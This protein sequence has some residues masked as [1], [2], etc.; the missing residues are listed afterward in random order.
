MKRLSTLVLVIML[1]VFVLASCGGNDTPAHEHSFAS[2]WTADAT[3]H[4]HGATC[5]HT[6]EKA[7][8]AAHTDADGNGKC[9][10][11]AYVIFTRDTVTVNAPEGVTV[12]ENLTAKTGTD[13]VFTASVSNNYLL[14]AEGADFVEK[15]VE[16]DT[17]TYSF[18]VTSV[19]AE[20]EVTITKERYV[21][22]DELL[23]GE[24]SFTDVVAW[25]TTVGEDITV[26]FDKA[27]TFY[28]YA[29]NPDVSF[30]DMPVLEVVIEE[31]GEMTFATSIYS[32]DALDELAYNYYVVEAETVIV[33]DEGGEY[34]LPSNME[35]VL[36]YTAPEKGWYDIT[37]DSDEYEYMANNGKIVYADKDSII[38][39]AIIAYAEYLPY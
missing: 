7:D 27:G 14:F 5:E 33:I 34:V 2:N 9:D 23:T 19:N 37:F 15:K 25:N 24:G 32:Y 1:L 3:G 17:A 10:A 8:F 39:T 38:E 36:Q 35:V 16:G 26:S 30:N 29:D 21:F 4:W 22:V 31:P 18:K 12:S 11:C 28:I 20:S 13:L 6:T